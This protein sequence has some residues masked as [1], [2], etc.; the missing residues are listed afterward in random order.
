MKVLFLED[1]PIIADIVKEH[2]TSQ[3]YDVDYAFDINEAEDFIEYN[4]Y[5]LFLFDVNVP[6]GNGFEFLSSIRSSSNNT[7]TIFITALNDVEDMKLGFDSG[8]D[9]YIKKPFELE[10][11]ELRINNIKRLYNLDSLIVIDTNTFLDKENFTITIGDM[12]KSLREKEFFLLEYLAKN[13]TRTISHDELCSNVWTY[14]NTPTDATIR[15]YI[16]TLR[17]IV[18]SEKIE[19]VKRIGYRFI[20]S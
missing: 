18:G 8:C 10:E 20:K 17:A 11:L 13:H 5:D 19:T 14:E 16:R 15:S 1:D 12:K 2:L 3:G 7:P 6:D 9:D 4:I